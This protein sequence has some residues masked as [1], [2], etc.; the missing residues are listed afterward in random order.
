LFQRGAKAQTLSTVG[1]RRMTAIVDTSF[2]VSLTNPAEANHAACLR[3]AETLIESLIVPQVILPEVA[4]LIAKYQGGH[5]MWTF[6]KRLLSP[7]WRLE[8]LQAADL[9]RASALLD[10]YADLDLDFPDAC[11]VGMAERLNVCRVLT[12]DRR[13]FAAVRPRHCPLF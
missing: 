7:A 8:P 12:L 10:Q 2:L 5:V 1:M 6:V 3:V 13:H 9:A 4:Y 11:I